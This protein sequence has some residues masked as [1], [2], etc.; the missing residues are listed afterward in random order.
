MRGQPTTSSQGFVWGTDVLEP[1]QNQRL[2]RY[3]TLPSLLYLLTERKLHFSRLWQLDD[4]FEGTISR[5]QAN[6]LLLDLEHEQLLPNLLQLYTNFVA[7]CAISCWHAN[8]TESLAM[9]KLYTTGTDGIAIATT[10]GKLESSL[11]FNGRGG[12]DLHVGFVQYIDHVADIVTERPPERQTALQSLFQKRLEY[13]HE[14]EVRFVFVLP[15]GRARSLGDLDIPLKDL[16]FI[17]EIVMS[18]GYP[19]W[20]SSSLQ[21]AL[22]KLG[23]PVGLRASNLSRGHPFV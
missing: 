9:W 17:D 2:W 16:S 1:S 22:S 12:L 23:A 7:G 20:A 18:P 3:I 10:V 14:Q 19:P 6:D 4:P 8:E 21:M 13:R 11:E 15:Q 5:A